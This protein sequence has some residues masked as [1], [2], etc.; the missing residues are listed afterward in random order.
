M[1][2]FLLWLG[3]PDVPIRSRMNN[4][5]DHNPY[6]APREAASQPRFDWRRLF[7][8]G[9][10]I[11]CGGFVA[12]GVVAASLSPGIESTAELLALIAAVVIGIVFHV[13]L[14]MAIAG[15]IGWAITM[16]RRKVHLIQHH[17]VHT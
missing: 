15:G 13:G 2:G 11:A 7:Y 16:G 3:L 17:L 14:L 6:T 4:H 12:L 5:V 9:L 8:R 10:W 1:T